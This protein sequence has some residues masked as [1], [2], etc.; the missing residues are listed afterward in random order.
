MSLKA[1]AKHIHTHNT[2]GF[3]WGKCDSYLQDS[4]GECFI[5]EYDEDDDDEDECVTLFAGFLW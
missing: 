2:T 1:F 5:Q 3:L 4:C